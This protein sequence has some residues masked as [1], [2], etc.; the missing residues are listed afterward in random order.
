M[1]REETLQEEKERIS[2]AFASIENVDLLKEVLT[3]ALS[4]S[5][6][7]NRNNYCKTIFL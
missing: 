1:F 3:F 6:E 4:V 5:D 2:H 7:F